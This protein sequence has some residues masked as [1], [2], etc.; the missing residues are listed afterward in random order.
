MKLNKNSVAFFSKLERNGNKHKFAKSY[1]NHK[2]IIIGV[3]LVG[4][5][6]CEAK[7]VEMI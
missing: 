2:I 6:D 3:V 1:R 7:N 4:E 5:R